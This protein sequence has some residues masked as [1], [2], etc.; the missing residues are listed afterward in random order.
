MK[1]KFI[2]FLEVIKGLIKFPI[3]FVL[4]VV[5]FVLNIIQ[6]FFPTKGCH[7]PD[8]R[9]DGQPRGFLPH[10]GRAAGQHGP[11]RGEATLLIFSLFLSSIYIRTNTRGI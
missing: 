1:E 4:V 3:V 8:G 7:P 11:R 2:S 5:A 6:E 9:A 10:R